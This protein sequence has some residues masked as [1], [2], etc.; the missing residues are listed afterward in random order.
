MRTVSVQILM[1]N[2]PDE[3]VNCEFIW[4]ND[5]IGLKSKANARSMTVSTELR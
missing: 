3:E 5:I 4:L 1:E 2:S